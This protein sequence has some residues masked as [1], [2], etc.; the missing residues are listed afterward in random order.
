VGSMLWSLK[1]RLMVSLWFPNLPLEHNLAP[2]LGGNYATPV[3]I[4]SLH[5][6]QGNRIS[7]TPFSGSYGYGQRKP[8]D[9][10]SSH[11]LDS[12][13]DGSIE[14]SR[15][16]YTSLELD[17]PSFRQPSIDL[18]AP[19]RVAPAWERD[20][21]KPSPKSY[22][23]PTATSNPT[24]AVPSF[25]TDYTN[26]P[27]TLRQS[28]FAPAMETSALSRLKDRE[29]PGTQL[30]R[31]NHL[32]ISFAEESVL[33]TR[34]S[35]TLSSQM[36]A[37][38]REGPGYVLATKV[39]QALQQPQP[40]ALPSNTHA[41][42]YSTVPHV[43]DT[44]F[45]HES[46]STS[47]GRDRERDKEDSL[48]H[49]SQYAP[50]D[51]DGPW[52][53]QASLSNISAITGDGGG[54]SISPSSPVKDASL[55]S[56]HH[57]PDPMPLSGGAFA[58]VTPA[59][60]PATTL[61]SMSATLLANQNL[62]QSDSSAH[63]GG[64]AHRGHS[65]APSPQWTE[66]WQEL[67]KAMRSGDPPPEWQSTVSEST[68]RR[69]FYQVDAQHSQW[70]H[71][72]EQGAR[73]FER[74]LAET[75]QQ[76]EQGSQIEEVMQENAAAVMAIAA[77]LGPP[78]THHMVWDEARGWC[79]AEK[80]DPSRIVA[81]NPWTSTLLRLWSE[82]VDPKDDRAVD[83]AGIQPPFGDRGR[84]LAS[85]KGE[86][87]GKKAEKE[88]ESSNDRSVQQHSVNVNSMVAQEK[89]VHLPVLQ[90]QS[91][92]TPSKTKTKGIEGYRA[93]TNET[94]L[95]PQLQWSDRMV[96][97]EDGL[98]FYLP[99]EAHGE[100][101][102]DPLAPLP[103]CMAHPRRRQAKMEACKGMF[104]NLPDLPKMPPRESQ[105]HATQ[106]R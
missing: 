98:A 93:E 64:L 59:K 63:L 28:Q 4:E 80:N 61:P 68:G 41:Y 106:A 40:Y 86:G 9:S 50:P 97:T 90:Q 73:E 43:E 2:I 3:E 7:T 104:R 51:W 25:A 17:T 77:R 15:K 82:R 11:G 89:E 45:F 12:G 26:Q 87:E 69:Y 6:S 39:N 47:G 52:R 21:L 105:S 24:T 71:P 75:L 65:A 67:K 35:I 53:T 18:V 54:V 55:R 85:P 74:L 16:I 22:L 30:S 36:S 19:T 79:F 37:A 88:E 32:P 84:L 20:F 66:T 78:P 13:A 44:I 29:N 31:A 34:G 72:N 62:S 94:W 100:G 70:E 48:G 101:S 23:S 49:A 95:H 57:F 8:F 14:G 60:V 33:Q 83:P 5:T 10:I 81:T 99:E 1:C 58:R 96:D 103:I 42:A 38:P 27:P 46:A 91:P 76:K 102:A 92:S 56:S